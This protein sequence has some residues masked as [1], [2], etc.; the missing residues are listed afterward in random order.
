MQE[1]SNSSHPEGPPVGRLAPCSPSLASWRDPGPKVQGT[2]PAHV[3]PP[4]HDSCGAQW[5]HRYLHARAPN[6]WLPKLLRGFATWKNF[7]APRSTAQKTH[8]QTKQEKIREFQDWIHPFFDL[9]IAITKKEKCR[10]LKKIVTWV[11]KIH[12]KG[13]LTFSSTLVHIPCSLIEVAQHGHQSIAVTIRTTHIGS[14]GADIGNGNT[15]TTS[16]CGSKLFTQKNWTK[17]KLWC[18]GLGWWI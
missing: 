13:S 8:T 6:T 1:K 17:T 14:T 4:C 18:F 12:G 16:L 7:N 10:L 9:P 3:A 11:P 2:N 5:S 15:N